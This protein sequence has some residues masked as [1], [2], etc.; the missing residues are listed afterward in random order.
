MFNIGLNRAVTLIA[1]KSAKGPRFRRFGSDP[2]RPLGE[3]PTK[4]GPIVAKNGRYGP[5]VSH[6]GI[7]ATLP[8]DKTPETITL[9]EAAALIDARAE[10][11]PAPHARPRK[12]KRAAGPGGGEASQTARPKRRLRGRPSARRQPSQR[13]RRRKLPNKPTQ[14]APG[15]GHG[16]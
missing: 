13:A 4:G 9:E 3:H 2:G 7:N 11:G 14:R 8:R 15:Q 12:G 16:Q 6:D 1:E 10:R 5:Y